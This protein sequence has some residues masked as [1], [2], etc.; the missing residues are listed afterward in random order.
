VVLGSTEAI[1]PDDLPEPVLDRG[2]P[3]ELPPGTYHEAVREAKRQIIR[4][5]LEQAGGNYAEAARRLG[6]NVTYLHRLIRNLDLRG[7]RE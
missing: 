2:T 6:V 3:A 5:C 7:T 4:K 1:L